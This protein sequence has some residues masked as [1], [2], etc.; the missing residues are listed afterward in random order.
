MVRNEL[1]TTMIKSRWSF[2][3]FPF[4]YHFLFLTS[5]VLRLIGPTNE[6]TNLCISN[7]R[8]AANTVRVS[9]LFV[10]FKFQLES[11]CKN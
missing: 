6:S 7:T 4:Q 10:G 11:R 5:I 3:L 8:V 9:H 1:A 2:W